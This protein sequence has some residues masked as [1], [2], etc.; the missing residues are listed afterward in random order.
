M[1]PDPMRGTVIPQIAVK[2]T[3]VLTNLPDLPH[4]PDLPNPLALRAGSSAKQVLFSLGLHGPSP[5]SGVAGTGEGATT[6]PPTH[7]S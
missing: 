1:A 3:A 6:G 4:Q 7:A 5:T 2:A